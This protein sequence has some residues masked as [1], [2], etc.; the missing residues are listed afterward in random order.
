MT[1]YHHR[2]WIPDEYRWKGTESQMEALA[3]RLYKGANTEIANMIVANMEA[4]EIVQ[5]L[6]DLNKLSD[7][8][9][10]QLIIAFPKTYSHINV[11]L[12]EADHRT[13][14]LCLKP[15]VSRLKKFDMNADDMKVRQYRYILAHGNA[16]FIKHMYDNISDEKL[17]LFGINEWE[18]LL[19][20]C[21]DAARRFDIKAI[22]N[23][24]HLRYLILRKPHILHYAS[25][26]DMQ[27]CTIDAPTWIRIITKMAVKDRRHVPAGFK[28]WVGRDVFKKKL[29]GRKFKGFVADWANGLQD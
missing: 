12:L 19:S 9:K 2:D 24:S 25:I 22:R 11:N 14:I 26:D 4:D 8:L 17:A 7:E 5:R 20:Y 29:T 1:R 21:R 27:N 6:G 18:T 23:Q 13:I 3:Q 10:T 16:K 28:A 15:I